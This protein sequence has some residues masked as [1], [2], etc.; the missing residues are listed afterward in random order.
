MFR[1]YHHYYSSCI[2]C[3]H[4]IFP[5]FIIQHNRIKVIEKRIHV[6]Q[7][8]YSPYGTLLFINLS[9]NFFNSLLVSNNVILANDIL[10]LNTR[11]PPQYMDD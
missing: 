5:V 7:L 1:N 11:K 4:L 10:S 2:V 8:F 3:I 6:F 9:A